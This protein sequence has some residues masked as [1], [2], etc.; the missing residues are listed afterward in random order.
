MTQRD[1]PEADESTDATEDDLYDR[2]LDACLEGTAEPPEAYLAG[3]PGASAGLRRRL[4]SLYRAIGT[5]AGAGLGTA[6]DATGGTAPPTASGDLPFARIGGYRLLRRLGTGGMGT[7]YL[8]EQDT[9]RRRVALKI[10]RS[11]LRQSDVIVRRFEREAQSVARL[12]HPN[13]VT[14]Y[15]FGTEDDCNFIAMELVRGRPLDEVLR[16]DPPEHAQ[17]LA[18]SIQVARA[19]AY[20]H[21]QGIVH[22]DVKPQNIMITSEGRAVLL[23]FGVAHVMGTQVTRLT[24]DFAGSPLYAAPEQLREA[25]ENLDGRADVYALGVT[26]YEALTG[27]APFEGGRLDEVLMRILQEEPAPPRTFAPD[28]ERDLETVI[29]KTLEKQ[30]AR[31]YATAHDLADDLQRVLE[32]RPIQATR[33]GPVVRATKW[34]RRHPVAATLIAAGLVAI[35]ATL[36]LSWKSTLD[37]RAAARSLVAEA[38]ARVDALRTDRL[39]AIAKDERMRELARTR[40]AR[41]FTREEDEEL[42]ALKDELG[43]NRRERDEGYVEVEEKLTRAIRLDSD[44]GGVE[45]VR[46]RLFLEQAEEARTAGNAELEQFWRKRLARQDPDQ[47]LSEELG[48]KGRLTLSCE[49]DAAELY[50]FRFEEQRQLVPGGDRRL[51][52]VPVNTPPGDLPEPLLRGLWALRV[53]RGAGGLVQGDLIVGLAGHPIRDGVFAGADGR[54][55]RR[56]DRLVAIDDEPATSLFQLAPERREGTRR[57]RFERDAE[58]FD[59]LVADVDAPLVD[60]RQLAEGGGIE[61]F[62]FRGGNVETLELPEGLVV[63]PTAAPRYRVATCRVGVTPIDRVIELPVGEYVAVFRCEG[64]EELVRPFRILRDEQRGVDVHLLPEGTTPAGFVHVPG[65]DYDED[66]EVSD[67]HRHTFWIMEREV[68]GREYAEFLTA[69]GAAGPPPPPD[70]FVR[71]SDGRWTLRPGRDPSLPV[72]EISWSAANAYAKWRSAKE[73]RPYALPRVPE[74]RRALAP[75]GRRYTYG[76]E[77]HP[78]WSN[79]LHSRPRSRPVVEPP[80]SYPIDESPLGVYDATGSVGEWIDAWWGEPR[81]QNKMWT[82]GS[83]AHANPDLFNVLSGGGYRAHVIPKFTGFRLVLRMST[84]K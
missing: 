30:P 18:W 74:W 23:D 11:E 59:V 44:V 16:E 84:P 50:L 33:P 29:L 66:P 47:G 43:A 69:L 60:A 13:I 46:A 27:R 1:D 76:T 4:D 72:N 32:H 31:R 52:P 62:V 40:R 38:D 56:G 14:V 51:V 34:T 21:E 20:A 15:E 49:P 45:A 6:V 41:Y 70:L 28:I 83:L 3:H 39:D 64:Y 71:L 5:R 67:F 37:D 26:L 80:F 65:S 7:V 57:L 10:V 58:P 75:V 35:L 17:I 12:R 53:V 78:K 54:V 24:S 82:G 63:R 8:A 55:L 79:A 22:R 61:A 25:S 9:L 73:G 68:N 81:Q 48:V 36:G 2:Y 42:D 19:L 77:F